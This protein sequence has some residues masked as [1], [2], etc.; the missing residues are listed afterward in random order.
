MKDKFS[1]PTLVF[2]I[3]PHQMLPKARKMRNPCEICSPVIHL[4]R[5]K[6]HLDD[7]DGCMLMEVSYHREPNP[8]QPQRLVQDPRLIVKLQ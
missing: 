6:L 7:E 2:A 1:R 5:R 3:P 8:L 4:L